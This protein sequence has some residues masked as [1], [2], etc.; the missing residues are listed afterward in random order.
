MISKVENVDPKARVPKQTEAK[1]DI[2]INPYNYNLNQFYTS[3]LD[4]CKRYTPFLT[5]EVYLCYRR[6]YIIQGTQDR[7][8]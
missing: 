3:N 8:R 7:K 6:V 5:N 1:R 2:V 4:A